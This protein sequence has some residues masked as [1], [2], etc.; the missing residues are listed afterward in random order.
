[1]TLGRGGPGGD[2]IG[3]VRPGPAEFG[4]RF[5]HVSSMPRVGARWRAYPA[6][7]SIYLRVL[8]LGL[9]TGGRSTVG[10]TALALTTPRTGSWLAG[11]R[12]LCRH[13]PLSAVGRLR[14]VGPA[15]LIRVGWIRVG[16]IRAGWI[17][18]IRLTGS[19]RAD[20]VRRIQSG[21]SIAALRA[22]RPGRGP[23]GLH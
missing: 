8:L 16:W 4:S 20:P 5:G 2:P 3:E 14:P 7:M 18:R 10:I 6:G 13:R 19:G 21:T 9:A 23:A 17:G 15:R 11:D 12:R 1:R 22:D